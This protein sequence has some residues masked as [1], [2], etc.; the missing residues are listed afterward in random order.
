MTGIPGALGCLKGPCTR[1]LMGS[2]GARVTQEFGLAETLKGTRVVV[3]SPGRIS[4]S[5]R[6]KPARFMEKSLARKGGPG[7]FVSFQV[8]T[9]A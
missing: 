5:N 6:T 4:P 1:I 9:L 7:I 2:N 8:F 3:V